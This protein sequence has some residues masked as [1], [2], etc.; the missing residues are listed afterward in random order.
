MNLGNIMNFKNP[1]HNI[2]KHDYYV[3]KEHYINSLIEKTKNYIINL[4]HKNKEEYDKIYFSLK[5]HIESIKHDPILDQNKKE[6]ILNKLNFVMNRVNEIFK[7]C[8]NKVPPLNLKDNLNLMKNNKIMINTN[9]SVEF[10]TEQEIIDEIGNNTKIFE[11]N[12]DNLV[13]KKN[14]DL[15]ENK[16]KM[17]EIIKNI[18][19]VNISIDTFKN[20]V[21]LKYKV[22]NLENNKRILITN[23]NNLKNNI[24]KINKA[25]ENERDLMTNKHN[26]LMETLNKEKQQLK[27]R[28]EIEL[29]KSQLQ[30]L[31]VDSSEKKEKVLDNNEE[32]VLDNNEEKVLDDNEEFIPTPNLSIQEN[33]TLAISEK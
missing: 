22:T 23:F 11:I 16:I 1:N 18:N 12:L 4:K 15:S 32:K 2:N 25:Y 10:Q 26:N 6:I 7:N 5:K 3:S 31:N 20:N 28:K 9:R 8:V 30:G 33:I 14:N 29:V 13:D 27:I 17:D 19:D 24:N 21:L